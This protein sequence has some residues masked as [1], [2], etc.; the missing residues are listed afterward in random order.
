MYIGSIIIMADGWLSYVYFVVALVHP[1]AVFAM[2]ANHP[3]YGYQQR[4]SS[5][6]S[7]NM[8]S[9]IENI[10]PTATADFLYHH[11]MPHHS[12]PQLS[13]SSAHSPLLGWSHSRRLLDHNKNYNHSRKSGST[14]SSPISTVSTEESHHLTA[15]AAASVDNAAAL[16]AASAAAINDSFDRYSSQ[17]LL[18]PA[19]TGGTIS[20]AFSET[21]S[22]TTDFPLDLTKP[23]SSSTSAKG[24]QRN[25]HLENLLRRNRRKRSSPS[26]PQWQQTESLGGG[27]GGDMM[28]LNLSKR[29]CSAAESV[30]E[31]AAATDATVIDL[32]D[33][34]DNPVQLV[35]L[36]A[37]CKNN[38]SAKMSSYLDKVS[39]IIPPPSRSML[40]YPFVV[41]LWI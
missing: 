22:S 28:P 17:S 32:H 8:S 4:I 13:S 41:S 20:P 14:T 39:I 29:L 3:W 34:V 10:I 33:A 38:V 25:S 31:P 24:Q 19:A 1:A 36:A 23:K 16:A 15:S 35:T 7:N 18:S 5:G 30:S 27:S 6:S 12:I 21:G 11:H 26:P 9:L 40:A 2:A 37:V